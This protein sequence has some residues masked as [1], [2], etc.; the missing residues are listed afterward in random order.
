MLADRPLVGGYLR[1]DS[2]LNSML[3]D[4]S[5]AMLKLGWAEDARED[6][7]RVL[8]RV[9]RHAKALFRRAQAQLTLKA[10][11]APTFVTVLTRGVGFRARDWPLNVKYRHVNSYS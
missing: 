2:C 10:C 5:A 4:R 1:Y 6:C 3:A 7:S 11:R 8:E 9:P